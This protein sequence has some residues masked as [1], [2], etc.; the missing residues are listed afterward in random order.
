M[1]LTQAHAK[2][3]NSGC[4]IG[5]AAEKIATGGDDSRVLEWKC[6]KGKNDD[7]V[8]RYVIEKNQ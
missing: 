3:V 8:K 5:A 4:F 6:I 7:S 1:C 2:S